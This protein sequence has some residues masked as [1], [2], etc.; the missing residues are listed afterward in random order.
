MHY[1]ILQE[2]ITHSDLEI[3][4]YSFHKHTHKR[5]HAKM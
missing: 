5:K 3:Y 4:T 1:N 2:F